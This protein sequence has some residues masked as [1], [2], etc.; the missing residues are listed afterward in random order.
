M[1]K[2]VEQKK[3]MAGR[4]RKEIEDDRE[5]VAF[6]AEKSSAELQSTTAVFD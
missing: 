1:R 6:V 3:L 5:F 2:V 4:E